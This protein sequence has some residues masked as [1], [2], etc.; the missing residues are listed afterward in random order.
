MSATSFP[1]RLELNILKDLF[2]EFFL[3]RPCTCFQLDDIERYSISSQRS[4][5]PALLRRLVQH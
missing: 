2:H 3:A 4:N 1:L 5:L